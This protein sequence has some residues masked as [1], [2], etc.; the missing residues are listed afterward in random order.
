MQQVNRDK[1]FEQLA[2]AKYDNLP[3]ELRKK[4][5]CDL[6]ELSDD[7]M[8]DIESSLH[9]RDSITQL[10]NTVMQS[11]SL[12]ADTIVIPQETYLQQLYRRKM[13]IRAAR[14]RQ[15]SLRSASQ[16]TFD[17]G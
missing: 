1:A 6:Y 4:V 7:L 16:F 13:R 9:K 12:A 3:D 5:D 17:G 11:D 14:W 10:K 2:N 15:D 8:V